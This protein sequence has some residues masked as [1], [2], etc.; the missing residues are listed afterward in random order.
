MDILIATHN[1]KKRDELRK[2][3]KD[4][5]DINIKN[6]S[7]IRT[8]P[9]NIVEDGKTFRQNAVKKAVTT[10]K[11]FNGLVLAD[12]SGLEVEA[13]GG[14]PGVRSA[15]FARKNA[16]DVENNDKLLKLMEKVPQEERKARF[17]CHIA[18]AAG[19]VLL[20]TFE[21]EISGA[22]RE[23]PRGKSGFGYDPLFLPDGYN[24]TFAEMPAAKKNAIS[25]RALALEKVRKEITKYAKMGRSS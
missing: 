4:F 8:T 19:G 18:L 1:P 17:V 14:K 22:I 24:K 5:E 3:L 2:I 23:K 15:R 20:G 25:H 11:F 10:S 13:L 6:F 12:D 9:P 21:G 16:T 7:D